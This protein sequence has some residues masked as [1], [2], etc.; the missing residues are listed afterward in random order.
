MDNSL[1]VKYSRQ[2]VNIHI[3][4]GTSSFRLKK[5]GFQTS[6]NST[7][8][9]ISVLDMQNNGTGKSETNASMSIKEKYSFTWAL[10]VKSYRG[11]GGEANQYS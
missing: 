3:C 1:H 11:G 5:A 9:I 7:P 6:V 2:R 10:G 4:M 8:R